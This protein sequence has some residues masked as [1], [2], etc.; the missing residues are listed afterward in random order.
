MLTLY[1][2]ISFAIDQHDKIIDLT[3]GL[4]GMKDLPQLESSL[5]FVKDDSYYPAFIDKIT[6]LVYSVAMNHCFLDGNKRSSIVLGAYFLEINGYD[7]LVPTFIL[8]MENIVLW[9]A[10]HFIGKDELKIFIN[11]ILIKG[12]FDEEDKL[13]LSGIL[14]KVQ[15]QKPELL[16]APQS[17]AKKFFDKGHDEIPLE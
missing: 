2:P 15:Q 17:Q 13:M 14:I 12:G 9:V 1:I 8:E 10:N 16:K 5:E 6:H 3:G 7:N 11:S 4:H